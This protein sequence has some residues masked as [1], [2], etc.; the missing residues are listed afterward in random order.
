MRKVQTQQLFDDLVNQI[1]DKDEL[2]QVQDEFFKHGVEVWL[3]PV[4]LNRLGY[5]LVMLFA[6]I[7]GLSFF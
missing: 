3:K 5:D 4:K 7:F 2:A 6:F 1:A